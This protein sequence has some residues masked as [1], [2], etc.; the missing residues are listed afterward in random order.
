MQ[1]LHDPVHPRRRM[2]EDPDWSIVPVAAAPVAAP[3]VLDC[4]HPARPDALGHGHVRLAV[5]QFPALP[6]A[7]VPAWAAL[8][9][10]WAARAA[11]GGAQLAMLPAEAA[12]TCAE[13]IAVPG[14]APAAALADVA[15]MVLGGLR[16]AARQSGVWL[17]GGTLPLRGSDGGFRIV[18]PLAAPDGRIALQGAGPDAPPA[19]FD[20]PFGRLGISAGDD[21]GFPKHVR[22]QVEAGAWLIL[23]PA[24]ATDAR[25]VHRL[26]LAAAARAME[27]RCHV[28]LAMMV[29][30]PC[31]GHAAVFGPLDPGFPEDGIMARGAMDRPE[32]VFCDLDTH[33]LDAARAHGGPAWP[34]APFPACTPANFV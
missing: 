1:P 2:S 32:W 3:V 24:R 25:G 33:G 21:I 22:A 18:A 15:A 26:H 13:A 28:G 30:P 9:A 20:T 34:R 11:A 17:L 19:V 31:R 23:A 10:G 6:L 14:V 12:M 27:N 4:G 29:G 16:E 7:G 5:A 8:V